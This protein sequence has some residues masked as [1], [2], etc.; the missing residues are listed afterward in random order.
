MRMTRSV[1]WFFLFLLLAIDAKTGRT[2]ETGAGN[3]SLAAYLP[4]GAIGTLETARLG[5]LIERIETSGALQMVLDSPQWREALKQEQV[6]KA[7][8]GKALAEGQLGM[9]LWQFAKTYLGDRMILGVYPPMQPGAQPEG[10]IIIRV[11]DGAS[12]TRLWD[13]LTPLIP[14]AGEKLKISDDAGGGRLITVDDGGLVVVRD[15]WVVMSK[16]KSLLDQTLQNLVNPLPTKVSLL[17]TAAWKEMRTQLGMDHHIQL[18]VNIAGITQLAGHR[19]IPS[20]LD[21]PVFSLL[22]GG[23]L[24]LAAGSPYLGSTLDVHENHFE[25]KSTVGGDPKQLDAA[26]RPYVLDGEPTPRADV[27]SLKSPLNGFSLTR[28]F[29]KW[30]RNRENLLDQSLLPN[31]DKFETGL[32]TFLPGR[33]FG[34]EVLPLLGQRL[35]IVSAPQSYTH[36]KGKPGVQLPG[37]ALLLDLAKPA[38]A[39]DVLNLVFQSII[40]ISNFQ[41]AQEGR[42][43]FVLSSEAY[44]ETQIAFAKYVKQPDGA[45]LPISYN[46]QPAS[47]RVGNRYVFA[48]SLELCRELVDTLKSE[49]TS[50]PA[51]LAGTQGDAVRDLYFELSPEIGADLLQ[52]NQQILTAQNLQQGKSAEQ[53]AQE[54]AALFKILRQLTPIKFSSTRYAD[55]WVLELHGGWK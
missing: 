4:D 5:P 47:A 54:L 27:P 30:Y 8:A 50:P 35:T 52:S 2:E 32:A 26:H 51:T 3:G 6:Q 38:E 49:A 34:E 53:S 22:F 41:A 10:V 55:R 33:D 31:F 46:F 28:D 25:L 17:E 14:L 29:S 24:E 12:L 43:P 15:R 21:N 16:V 48:T 13:R 39:N 1:G 36:L 42:Q 40:L 18:C 37:F 19:F 20:K 11:N 45:T 44:H 23:Y 9:S 7:L